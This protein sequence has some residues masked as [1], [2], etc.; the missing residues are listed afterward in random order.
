[1]RRVALI[2]IAAVLTGLVVG[3]VLTGCGS[4]DSSTQQ[5]TTP[6]LTV[7]SESRGTTGTTGSGTTDGGTTGDTGSGT[8]TGTGTGG[9]PPAQQAP[10]APSGGAQAAPQDTPQNDTPPAAG[11]PASR[12]ERFCDQNPGAC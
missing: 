2:S 5:V 11:S 3:Q 1:M 4:D 10:S 12:Y 6:E 7:P 8:G 9:S